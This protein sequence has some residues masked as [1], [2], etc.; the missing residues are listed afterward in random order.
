LKAAREKELVTY[1]EV[2][3]RL[4]VDF[5]AETLQAGGNTRFKLLKE[6]KL[7]AKELCLAKIPLRDKKETSILP[8][9]QNLREFIT[10]RHR[11]DVLQLK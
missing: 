8:D 7:P 4:S 9:K 6:K 5:S 3:T 2:F 10:T 11:M 1:K